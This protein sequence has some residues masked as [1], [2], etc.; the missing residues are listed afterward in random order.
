MGLFFISAFTFFHQKS[1]I[2]N[3]MSLSFQ[4]NSFLHVFFFFTIA[5][6]SYCIFPLVLFLNAPPPPARPRLLHHFYLN[7]KALNPASLS[8]V[9]IIPS[10]KTLLTKALHVLKVFFCSGSCK[11]Q[12]TFS[13]YCQA[14]V[15]CTASP[16]GLTHQVCTT[17]FINWSERHVLVCHATGWPD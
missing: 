13:K 16:V 14:C 8:Q 11:W 3:D 4:D 15:C 5:H 7:T 12:Q 2:A 9:Y 10:I 1:V 17:Y 6:A